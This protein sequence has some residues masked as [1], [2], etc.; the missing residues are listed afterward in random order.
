MI[1]V[2]NSANFD[3]KPGTNQPVLAN[4]AYELLNKTGKEGDI[5]LWVPARAPIISGFSA[6]NSSIGFL[7]FKVNALT[8][9]SI[10]FNFVD[11]SS[12][13][14]KWSP[15]WCLTD[16][17]FNILSPTTTNGKSSVKVTGWDGIEL[18]NIDLRTDKSF[19]DWIDV[20]IYIEMGTTADGVDVITLY[21][22]INDA[23]V[24][25]ATKEITTSTGAIN[26]FCITG[27][28]AYVGSGIKLDDIAFGYTAHGVWEAAQE[29]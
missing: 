13:G 3:T 19:T 6:A 24:G 7:S 25:S 14:S 21:Y 1:G 9:N 11:T 16:S 12:T 29:Q 15:E 18:A 26:S 17:F 10:G 22:Y 28:T 5:E 27:S 20:A 8:S 4:G 23:Y 2:G